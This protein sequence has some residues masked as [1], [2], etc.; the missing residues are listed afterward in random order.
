MAI[1]PYVK[2]GVKFF[3]VYVTG[4][5]L[6]GGLVQRRKKGITSER[7]AELT[8]FELKKEVE[9]IRKN[10]PI[11][12]W[13]K[14]H[15]ETLK[16][17]RLNRANSTVISFDGQLKKWVTPHWGNRDLVGISP[18]DVYELTFEKIKEVSE[19]T[20]LKI[21]KMIRR[22]FEMAVVEGLI[23]K[24]PTIGITVRVPDTDKKVLT[25]PE[26]EILL[27]EGKKL[28]HHFY[29]IW[30]LAAMTG[31]RSGELYA[32]KWS[33]IDLD[34]KTIS[35]NKQWTSK[36]G[37][38]PTK[39]RECRVVPVREDDLLGFLKELKLKSASQNDFVLPHPI[40]WTNG[41]Q[42]RVIGDFC[43]AIGI[44]RIKFHD[45]RATL[46]TNLL[47]RGTPLPT[48]MAI[49]GHSKIDTTNEYLRLAGVTVQ[50]GTDKLG[51]KLPSSEVG[52]VLNF[53]RLGAAG[54]GEFK[55]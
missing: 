44:T 38:G 37:F 19:F 30:A 16:R 31:M 10:K 48:V 13:D 17:M 53:K 32:L 47:A 22:V 27:R 42:A 34:G 9:A 1:R 15:A 41:E 24:N 20:R 28:N 51:Y 43:E 29:E 54:E 12:T 39:T 21:L 35:V 18:T 2:D 5:D 23:I 49:V 55:L 25:A 40:E 14:W 7:K 6:S 36:N 8:E 45:L 3:E 26:V 52:Q 50:N 33:D 11:W 4:R 46:I